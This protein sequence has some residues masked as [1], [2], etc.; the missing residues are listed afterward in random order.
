[1]SEDPIRD[2]LAAGGPNNAER[3]GALAMLLNPG[4]VNPSPGGDRYG[5]LNPAWNAARDLLNDPRRAALQA[6][7]GLNA[8]GQTL[9]EGDA[10]PMTAPW[11]P[12]AVAAGALGLAWALS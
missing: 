11:V 12:I 7:T 4:W 10:N 8:Y 1:V 5:S 3:Q 2:L 6:S 9:G